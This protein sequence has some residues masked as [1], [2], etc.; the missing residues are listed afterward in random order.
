[1]NGGEKDEKEG[2]GGGKGNKFL[3]QLSSMLL[4]IYLFCKLIASTIE[5]GKQIFVLAPG[6][7]HDT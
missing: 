2:R 4:F 5:Q 7:M 1:M 3:C 6:T